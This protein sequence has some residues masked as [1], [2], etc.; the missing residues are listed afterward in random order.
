MKKKY[1]F[2]D[3]NFYNDRYKDSTICKNISWH[4]YKFRVYLR[5]AL[6]GAESFILLP[7]TMLTIFCLQI[8]DK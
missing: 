4:L 6:D 3:K 8:L 1:G 7:L 5:D 2:N